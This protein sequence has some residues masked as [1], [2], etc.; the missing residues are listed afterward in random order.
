ML[1]EKT[2]EHV[3]DLKTRQRQQKKQLISNQIIIP[4]F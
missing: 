1:I 2:S 4:D 3:M